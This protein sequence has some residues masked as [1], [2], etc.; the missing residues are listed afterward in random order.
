MCSQILPAALN[1]FTSTVTFQ[2]DLIRSAATVISACV[3][4]NSM[5][6]GLIAMALLRFILN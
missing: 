1:I 3:A 5:F 6:F 4:N 2:I